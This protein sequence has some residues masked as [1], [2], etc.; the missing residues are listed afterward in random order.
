MFLGWSRGSCGRG[1][2]AD[3]PTKESAPPMPGPK[4]IHM[5]IGVTDPFTMAEWIIVNHVSD[6]FAVTLVRGRNFLHDFKK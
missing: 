4:S 5:H 3:M 1:P 2:V 6:F